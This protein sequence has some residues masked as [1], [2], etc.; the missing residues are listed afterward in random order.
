[1]E[2]YYSLVLDFGESY[3]GYVGAGEAEALASVEATL[4]YHMRFSGILT[5]ALIGWRD[6]IRWVV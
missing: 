4:E 5:V 3:R 2:L 1:M 6:S